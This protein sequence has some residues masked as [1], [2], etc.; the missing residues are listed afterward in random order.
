MSLQLAAFGSAGTC[1]HALSGVH[2]SN[3][4]RNNYIQVIMENIIA[5]KNSQDDHFDSS[6]K[7]SLFSMENIGTLALV[8]SSFFTDNIG[9][10]FGVLNTKIWDATL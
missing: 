5:D 3:S 1:I 7:T 8:G 4:L 6:Y 10:V 9:S 2:D